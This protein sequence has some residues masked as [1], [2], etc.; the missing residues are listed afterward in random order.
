MYFIYYSGAATVEYPRTY[1]FIDGILKS[2][3]HLDARPKGS[4]CEGAGICVGCFT[5][6]GAQGGS[7]QRRCSLGARRF[8]HKLL[9][10]SGRK[11]SSLARPKYLV[12]HGLSDASAWLNP[13][14]PFPPFVAHFVVQHR[15]GRST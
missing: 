2:A 10:G 8:V 12:G 5:A 3:S 15:L 4:V 1:M 11:I 9:V 13:L 7:F 6:T 14:R